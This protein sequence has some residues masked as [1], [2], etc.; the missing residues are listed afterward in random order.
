[1]KHMKYYENYDFENMSR[2]DLIQEILRLNWFADKTLAE[3]DKHEKVNDTLMK[4]HPAFKE[5][6]N[7]DDIM[8]KL[9]AGKSLTEIGKYYGCDKKTIKNRLIRDGWTD[10]HID[11]LK[12]GMDVRKV[13]WFYN[14][15]EKDCIY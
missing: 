5:N 9:V 10:K 4:K 8:D 3:L 12:Q 2:E 11:Q 13:D 15:Y 7:A 6:I 14:D 1:M